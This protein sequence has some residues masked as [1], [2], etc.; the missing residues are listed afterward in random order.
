MRTNFRVAYL[1]N[2]QKK[3]YR[4]LK[5]S[6]QNQHFVRT[7]LKPRIFKENESKRVD[8][9][10]TRET[11]EGE[12]RRCLLDILPEQPNDLRFEENLH[13]LDQVKIPQQENRRRI[14]NCQRLQTPE[15]RCTDQSSTTT[16]TS[17]SSTPST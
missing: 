10:K 16:T 9:N 6:G 4:K 12:F 2:E 15:H 17:T 3:H 14:L 8:M 5:E 7:I 1:T 13:E 11:R